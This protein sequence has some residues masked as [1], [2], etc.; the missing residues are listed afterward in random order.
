MGGA[1]VVTRGAVVVAAVLLVA[2]EAVP[3][4]AGT[5]PTVV[6][7]PGERVVGSEP[8]V[9]GDDVEPD[10]V[11]SA[12]AAAVVG[13]AG[14]SDDVEAYGRVVT[15]ACRPD[16]YDR[17]GQVAVRVLRSSASVWPLAR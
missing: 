13:G 15:F 14:A 5:V 10:D 1:V 3:C 7:V 16:R 4:V 12:E 17:F 11:G 2:V 6:A 8:A 9:V